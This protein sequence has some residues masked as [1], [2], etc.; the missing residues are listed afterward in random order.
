MHLQSLEQALHSCRG[1]LYSWESTCALVSMPQEQGLFIRAAP[2]CLAVFAPREHPCDYYVLLQ[3]SQHAVCEDNA[4]MRVISLPS[5]PPGPFYPPPPWEAPP[6]GPPIPLHPGNTQKQRCVAHPRLDILNV[7]Q[8]T[9]VTCQQP[10]LQ[11]LPLDPAWF[12]HQWLRCTSLQGLFMVW[13]DQLPLGL[14]QMRH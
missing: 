9:V 2:V 8:G 5:S 11:K 14:R 4:Q 7:N 6:L 1:V 3:G 12:V 13:A 10:C